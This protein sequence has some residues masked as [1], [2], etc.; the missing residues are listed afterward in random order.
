MTAVFWEIDNTPRDYAWGEIDGVAHVRGTAP[1]G[2][3]EAELWLGAHPAAPSRVVGDAPWQTLD[4][5]ERATGVRLP[6]LLKILCAA[7]PLSLQAHPS[8]AQAQEGF[9]RENELGIPVDAP[10]RNYRDPNS[11]PEMIVALYDGFEALCGFRPVADVQSDLE[12]LSA[13]IGPDHGSALQAWS[14]LLAD[15][16][17]IRSAF[18]WLLSGDERI[19]PLVAAVTEVGAADDR[20]AVLRP[21][22]QA[23]PGDPGILGALMLQHVTLRAGEALWLPAGNIHAYLRGSGIELMGPSDNVLRGGLTPKHIDT[24]ELGRVLDAREGGDPRLDASPAGDGIRVFRP[25]A[26]DDAPGFVLYECTSTG[27]LDL[28]GAAVALCTE[29]A[30]SLSS[31]DATIDVPRGRA[32]LIARAARV[33]VEGEGRLFFAAGA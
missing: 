18:L 25:G 5:W 29:G 12:A 22:A 26:P 27:E 9:A 20:F 31:G 6:F 3:R 21:I 1:T 10:N 11:K 24:D 23:H 2:L 13:A 19:A 30:F 28:A 32:V 7:E 17:G 33:H 8:T 4:E 16:D 14:E 15:A